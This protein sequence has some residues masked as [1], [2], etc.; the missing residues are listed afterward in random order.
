MDLLLGG[1]LLAVAILVSQFRGEPGPGPHAVVGVWLDRT[2][3]RSE[4]LRLDGDHAVH[5]GARAGRWREGT[6]SVTRI[7]DG[8]D[9]ELVFDDGEVWSAHVADDTLV[10]TTRGREGRWQRVRP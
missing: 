4:S 2:G 9:V 3:G 7:R 5:L 10:V 8:L 6:P 1:A